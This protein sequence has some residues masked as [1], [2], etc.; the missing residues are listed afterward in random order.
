MSILGARRRP[1]GA[2]AHETTRT[3]P[4]GPVDPRLLAYAASTRRFLRG[5]VAI[6]ALGAALA[7]AQAW[8]LAAIVAGSFV[9]HDALGALWGAIAALGAVVAARAVLAWATERAA[10]RSSASAK[11]ELRVALVERIAELGPAGISTTKAGSLAQL[12]TTG[13]D[14][15]DD[16]FA[17]YLPQ[18]FLAVLVPLAV[19]VVIL[20]F[21]W[22]SALIIA[23]TVPLIPVFM[24]LIGA[25]TAQRT[26]RRA[27]VLDRLAGHFIDVVEGLPTLRVFRRARAQAASIAK[28]TAQYRTTT[29]A[30]LRLAFLSSLALELLATVSV[31][32]VA[33]VI[34][35]RLL[36]GHLGLQ[37]GLF[38][39]VLAPEAYMP[40]RRL[41]ESYHSSADGV[42]AAGAIFDVLDR[43][44]PPVGTRREVPA[45]AASSL[46]V[47]DLEV[48]YPDRRLP[49]V[50]GLCLRLDPG[51]RVA[52]VGP[53]GAGKS[54]T[55]AAI[56]GLVTP[57]VGRI[58]LGGVDIATLD[59][60]AW[61][62][63]L[64]WVPQRPHLFS[65]SLSDNIR[66]GA[67]GAS[68]DAVRVAASS[69]QLDEVIARLPAG[70]DTRL[71]ADGAGLS[72]GER[73]RV[74]LARAFLRD[75]PLLLLDEPTA[76]LDGETEH[77]VLDSVLRLV[78]G[79]TVL[80]VAHRSSLVAIADRVVEL[81]APLE[82]Q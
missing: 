58:E 18:L 41:G 16:Y 42:A 43:P 77:A 12:A 45:L 50:H 36:S 59:P 47:R 27:A 4:R 31:A 21:D 44:V 49:A 73:Q 69:A 62:R 60:A 67:P 9:H 61:R 75:A 33:V 2:V 65:G 8:L 37:V 39:L 28:V 40:L 1:S 81:A 57:S 70:L 14:A 30:T 15:L 53:S 7:I 13:V 71:G 26:A 3:A 55:L 34:G 19:I 79:R 78:E 80:L 25:A 66:L 17:R 6:G 51:E 11:S 38:V 24:A 63:N 46:V 23:L 5:S 20:G 82:P 72:I 32:L 54:T 10:H 29:M 64:A 74:A 76:S 56:L 52:L 48:T 22:P 68:A 35:L